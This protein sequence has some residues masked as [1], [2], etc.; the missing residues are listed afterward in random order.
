MAKKLPWPTPSIYKHSKKSNSKETLFL[1][2]K[3]KTSKPKI[4]LKNSN[5][6]TKMCDPTETHTAKACL[7]QRTKSLNSKE[8][9]KS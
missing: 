1:N 7:K 8:G 4:N 5:S 3:R 9:T 6:F 2:T